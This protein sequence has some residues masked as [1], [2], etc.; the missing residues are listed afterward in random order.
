[1]VD[2]VIVVLFL[3]LALRGW[4]RGFVRE[5]LDV[6]GLVVGVVLAFRLGPVVG[7]V[8]AAMSGIS[9]DAAR[10][11]GGLIVFVSVGVA[12]AVAV[13]F[14]EQRA[15]L[16]ALNVA[17]RVAGAGLALLWGV[18]L[19][20]VALSLAVILPMPSAVSNA[21]EGSAVTRVLTD[22]AGTP[23]TVFRGLAGNRIV[24]SLINLQ[25]AVGERMLVVEGDE[26]ITFPA[27]DPSELNIDTAA[28]SEVYDLVNRARVDSGVD[29]LAWSPA[30]CLVGEDH[31]VEMY[32][33]GYF[34]HVSPTTGSVA[35]RVREAGITYRVVGENL[36]LAATPDAVYEGFIDS[37]GHRVNMLR[38]EYRRVGVAVVS[39][40]LGLM[41]AVVFTG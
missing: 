24:E 12:V 27:A 31:A 29:P 2:A 1:M 22:P 11:V 3:L 38:T 25:R 39:G 37:P 4:S 10:L 9:G 17:N 16:P 23:Q 15:N 5:G 35:D 18:I 40:P 32:V 6:V 41:T 14:I 7:T 8:I 13:H 30:L 21:L 28:A 26:V 20:T 33:E 36:A 19:A 34:S